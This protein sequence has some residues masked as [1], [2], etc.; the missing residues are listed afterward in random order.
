M[1]NISK[2]KRDELLKKIDSIKEYLLLSIVFVTITEDLISCLNEL[3][4]E[5]DNK[6]YGLTF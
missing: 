3:K 2:V 4:L 1:A 5:I 6:K